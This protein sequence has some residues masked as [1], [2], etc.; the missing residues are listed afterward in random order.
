MTNNTT[1]NDVNLNSTIGGRG[2]CVHVHT[3]RTFWGILQTIHIRGIPLTEMNLIKLW[4]TLLNNL[5]TNQ[6]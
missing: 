1:H 6:R 3:H 4:Q 5:F 2:I